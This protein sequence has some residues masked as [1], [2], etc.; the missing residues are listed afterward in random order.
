ME[1]F[2]TGFAYIAGRFGRVEPLR[3][4]R[5]YLLGLL[6]DVQTRSCWQLAEHAG[7]SSPHRMQRHC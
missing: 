3:Q 6:A 1:H 7:D 5:D 4:A 2:D